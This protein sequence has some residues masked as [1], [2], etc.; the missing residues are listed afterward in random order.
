MWFARICGC[1]WMIMI[2]FS[3]SGYHCRL[4]RKMFGYTPSTDPIICRPHRNIFFF[5]LLFYLPKFQSNKKLFIWLINHLT[6]KKLHVLVRVSF[7]GGLG[8]YP[9]GG[10]N[11]A[12]PSTKRRPC[13]LTRAC[14]PNW[15]LSPKISKILPHFS[16][17]FRLL[18]SS[19]LHQKALSY[20]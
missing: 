2:I 15:V 19:K 1:F 20:S 7:P 13:F 8:G 12:H 11:F 4:K 10:K 14:P 5:K 9:P 6:I 18:S 3:T 17:N 16:L